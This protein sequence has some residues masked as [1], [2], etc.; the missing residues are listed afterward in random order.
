MSCTPKCQK[1]AMY[2]GSGHR[3]MISVQGNTKFPINHTPH[4][5]CPECVKEEI[6]EAEA[7]LDPDAEFNSLQEWV[8]DERYKALKRKMEKF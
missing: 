1:T 2:D 6:A 8:R 4:P 3:V 7:A 5:Q